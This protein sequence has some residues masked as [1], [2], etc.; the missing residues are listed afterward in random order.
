[1]NPTQRGPH[2]IPQQRCLNPLCERPIDAIGTLDGIDPP[3]KPGDPIACMRCGQVFT[4][5]ASGRLRPFTE[6]EAKDLIDDPQAMRELR[7]V[8]GSIHA[9]RLMTNPN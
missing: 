6:Q 5:D 9:V 4:A 7:Q 1:M 2:R 3:P 8:V